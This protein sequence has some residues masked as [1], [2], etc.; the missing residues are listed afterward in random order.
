MQKLHNEMMDKDQDQEFNDHFAPVYPLDHEKPHYENQMNRMPEQSPP[1]PES[2]LHQF[3][4]GF[5]MQQKQLLQREL[6]QNQ[7]A[8][9]ENQ[10]RQMK[11]VMSEPK[12]LNPG[13]AMSVSNPNLHSAMTIGLKNEPMNSAVNESQDS[14]DG[15]NRKQKGNV[16]NTYIKKINSL[17]NL[18]RIE[19]A[20]AKHERYI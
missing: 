2:K 15:G 19:D 1:I 10:Q 14:G 6:N 13:F 11:N 18:S 9:T 5:L 12:F 20:N 7:R 8:I 16:K 17:M 4:S 3:N